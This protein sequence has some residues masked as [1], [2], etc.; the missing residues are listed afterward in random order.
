ML[1]VPCGKSSVVLPVNTALLSTPI[2]PVDALYVTG[3]VFD[4]CAL[5]SVA[6]GPV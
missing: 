6:L 1:L 3:D 4:K 5:T 2:T